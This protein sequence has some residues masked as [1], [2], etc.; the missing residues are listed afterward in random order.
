MKLIELE[1]ETGK[2][3]TLEPVERMPLSEVDVILE[4]TRAEVDGSAMPVADGDE[5]TVR[6]SEPHMYNV[7]DG[8]A[9]LDGGYAVVVG[10]A[11]GY[12]G[13]QHKVRIDRAS[14]TAAYATLLDAKPTAMDMPPDPD[15]YELPEFERE[16]GERL[17]LEDSVRAPGARLRP[18][19]VRRAAAVPAA[20]AK[21]ADAAEEE[22][23]AAA[24]PRRRSRAKPAADAVAADEPTREE[25]TAPAAAAE[26]GESSDS[27]VVDAA[28]GGEEATANRRRRRG[29]R[30]GRGRSKAATVDGA[31]TAP[32]RSLI[33]SPRR[34]VRPTMATARLRPLR[35]PPRRRARAGGR[36]PGAPPLRRQPLPMRRPDAGT[37]G[38]ATDSA[39]PR[40]DARVRARARGAERRRASLE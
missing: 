9:R 1:K 2:R 40:A 23:P 38:P 33:P 13:Q 8:V 25:A 22:A 15:D 4:G 11:I 31:A 19:R 24:K 17:E 29:K 27:D 34:P 36:R 14:R 21:D 28:E 32:S 6:I 35:H 18:S 12:V 16:V 37:G 20:E 5:V 7:T 39:D 10:G 26:P 30:G 3:F